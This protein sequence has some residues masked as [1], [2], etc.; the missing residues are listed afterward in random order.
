MV[1]IR[2]FEDI[3]DEFCIQDPSA[4]VKSDN[5]DEVKMYFFSVHVNLLKRNVRDY[6]EHEV[7]V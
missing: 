4:V 7:F 1:L 6:I 5:L 3:Q 2:S